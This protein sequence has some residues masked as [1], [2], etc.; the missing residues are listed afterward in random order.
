MNDLPHCFEP[1]IAEECVLPVGSTGKSA[2]AE[3][4]FTKHGDKT[5]LSRNYNITPA[6]VLHALYY[7]E[8]RPGMP[9]VIFVNPTAGI[10]EGDRYTYDIRLD[11]DAEAFIT[12]NA[13]TK[14]Y[15]MDSNYG[16]RQ[17]N[18]SLGPRSRLEYLPKENIAF[19]GSRWHQTITFNLEED[20][21]LFF[22][23]I[24]CPGR[25]ARGESWDF[26]A[27]SSRIKILKDDQEIAVDNVLW[28]SEDKERSNILFGD[29]N[30]YLTAYL[31]SSSILDE[32]DNID[33]SQ[34][35]G[36]VSTLPYGAGLVSKALS[37][38]MDD[39]KDLQLSLWK[40]FRKS[41]TGE[42]VP[43]LRMQY[44]RFGF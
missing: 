24:F 20:A 5:Y 7:D 11:S 18:V 23:E 8:L 6:K 25:I 9:Y 16:S 41:E 35:C 17:I 2:V 34:V 38:D 12:D 31:V 19:A 13:A 37:N 27:Y 10:I 21:S 22:S 30:Y 29:M 33:L 32:K 39:L 36:G 44:G 4:C 42:A 43:N 1:Y 28:T 40:A 15:K 14:I 26:D 3:L